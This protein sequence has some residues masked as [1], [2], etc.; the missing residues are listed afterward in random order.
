MWQA[1]YGDDIDWLKAAALLEMVVKPDSDWM[2]EG[3]LQR[4]ARGHSHILKHGAWEAIC[5]Y[6]L[7][8]RDK[9]R[10]LYVEWMAGSG[11]RKWGRELDH[12]LTSIARASGCGKV[13]FVSERKVARLMARHFH[14]YRHPYTIYS[15]VIEV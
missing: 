11:F 3:I 13:E 15:K 5:V 4:V 7:H 10:I 14:S 12:V 1:V 2:V 6:A 9:R 8:D